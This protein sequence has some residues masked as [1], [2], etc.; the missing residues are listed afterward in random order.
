MIV[1]I[2]CCYVRREIRGSCVILQNALLLQGYELDMSADCRNFGAINV[3]IKIPFKKCFKIFFLLL[4]RR[5]PVLELQ[6]P[7]PLH[8]VLLCFATQSLRAAAACVK[9]LSFAAENRK[10]YWGGC[11]QAARLICQQI[12]AFLAL[13]VFFLKILSKSASFFLFSCRDP[14]FGAAVSECFRGRCASFYCV[15]QLSLCK[16]HWKACV[17]VAWCRGCMRNTIDY[18]LLQLKIVNRIGVAASMLR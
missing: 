15:L 5:D 18:C 13:I 3:P 1:V 9:L 8:V 6:V 14:D 4:W 7:R 11:I 12:F 10:S 17:K 2:W 16:L